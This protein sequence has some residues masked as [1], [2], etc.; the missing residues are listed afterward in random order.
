[1]KNS[2]KVI[3]RPS[4]NIL[5]VVIEILFLLESSI[6]Y[7]VEGVTPDMLASSLVVIPF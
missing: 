1:M 3:L 2:P 4:H 5:I 6:L 7:T